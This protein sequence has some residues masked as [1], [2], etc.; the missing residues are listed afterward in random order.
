MSEV[1]GVI[2]KIQRPADLS[3]D[4]DEDD[5]DI[6]ETLSE[7]LWGLTEMFPEPVRNVCGAISS[8]TL[9]GV[10]IGFSFSRCALWIASSSAA[11]M[12]LP[13]VFE[14]ER[15]QQHEQQLQQQR[16]ILLGPNAAV[17]G[18]QNMMPGMAGMMMPGQKQ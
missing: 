6:D 4:E 7:R 18:G 1:E 5:E 15:A 12:V 17:S 14:S 16:Q 13:I 2:E 11:I 10:K 9:S 3:I 8:F